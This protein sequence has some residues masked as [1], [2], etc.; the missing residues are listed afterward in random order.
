MKVPVLT[1][2][3]AAALDAE[4]IAAGTSSRALM[5]RAGRA[6]ASEILRRF[7]PELQRGVAIFAGP[8]NNG[9]DAWVV[10][11]AL[12]ANGVDVK[13]HEAREPTTSDARAERDAALNV[14]QLQPPGGAEQLAVDGL[15]G[16]GSSGAPRAEIAQA[17][18]MIHGM[19]RGGAIVVALDMP[20]GVDS[21]TG[22]SHDGVVADLTLSFGSIK[23]G[24]LLNRTSCGR[25]V[26]LDIGLTATLVQGD[27][28]PQLVHHSW[29]MQHV[30]A[31][32][33]DAHKGSRRRVAVAGGSQGMAGAAILAARAAFRSGV[34]LVR[35]LVPEA[36]LNIV[37]AAVPQALAAP[38]PTSALQEREL[39]REWPHA[40]V[41]GPGLGRS[42]EARQ[43]LAQVATN[44]C[45]PLVVDADAITLLSA[46]PGSLAELGSAM[47]VVLTPHAGEMSRL[48]GASV[49][50]V[51]LNRFE[52]AGEV[53]RSTGA[54]VLLKGVPTIVAAPDGRVHICAAGS[55]ALATGGSGDI[56]AGV[57]G[58]LAAQMSDLFNAA[59][60]S[61]WVHGRAGELAALRYSARGA[62][63]DH[64]LEQLSE[65]WSETQESPNQPV[66][67]ELAQ[68]PL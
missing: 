13:I 33:A 27:V 23:R 40:L 8:G 63:L 19:R 24:Q 28:Y 58:T 66:L 64:V 42:T 2:A 57:L 5:Q 55:P 51:L 56:L 45:G 35:L 21:T 62:S 61:A 4:T 14:L 6:A 46:E 20:T 18:S 1:A 15:L 22:E 65:V 39:L 10:A 17:V 59:I 34:G 31:I 11:A 12:A 49:A 29:V 9:G 43:L 38:W 16:T 52:I 67:C 60:C 54:I 47:P 30:P 53:A 41:L 48:A 25:V 26:A 68:V 7:A 37:Q 36:S 44:F 32:N 50:E 3:Q